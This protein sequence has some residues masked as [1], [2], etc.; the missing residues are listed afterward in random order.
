MI[1]LTLAIGVEADAVVRTLKPETRLRQAVRV[2]DIRRGEHR[3]SVAGTGRVFTTF[4][5]LKRELRPFCRL[6]GEVLGGVDIRCIHPSLLASI[7]R[8]SGEDVP[9][10]IQGWL[11]CVEGKDAATLRASGYPGL[12]AALS[13]SAPSR[14]PDAEL[15][16]KLALAGPGEQDVYEYLA[17]ACA[18]EGIDVL[19]EAMRP[20]K[21]VRVSVPSTARDAA[22]VCH[23]RY[24]VAL[25]GSY[26]PP[27]AWVFEKCFP[28][29]FA[30]ATFVNRLGAGELIRVLQRVESI[31]VIEQVAPRLVRQGV[32]FLTLH[33]AIWAGEKDVPAVVDAFNAVFG[34]IGVSLKLKVEGTKA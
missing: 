20:T 12:L 16:E 26:R 15:Y 29:V 30:C 14:G 13:R 2:D 4:T 3:F 33:D 23:M 27:F 18:A 9:S 21:R 6:D 11:R 31:I 22:K 5:G 28:S 34:D 17:D 1:A 10:Y 25:P 8:H 7:M 32:G 24:M 19:T